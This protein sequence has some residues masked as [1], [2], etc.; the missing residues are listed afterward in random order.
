M[1]Q[2]IHMNMGNKAPRIKSN[3][4]YTPT[5]TPTPNQPT[6]P[7]F[8]LLKSPMGAGTFVLRMQPAYAHTWP[9]V[10]TDDTTAHHPSIHG[11]STVHSVMHTQIRALCTRSRLA[12]T[13]CCPLCPHLCLTTEALAS[14]MLAEKNAMEPGAGT[15]PHHGRACNAGAGLGTAHGGEKK[16][17]ARPSLHRHVSEEPSVHQCVRKK[18]EPAQAGGRHGTDRLRLCFALHCTQRYASCLGLV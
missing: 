2:Q 11:A 3:R 14:P 8:S 7:P 4:C 16:G 10:M 13:A 12:T 15:A 17:Q 6:N 5:P 1:V 18:A 9:R